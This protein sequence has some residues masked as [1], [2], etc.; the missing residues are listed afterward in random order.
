MSTKKLS[1]IVLATLCTLN[2]GSA[3]GESKRCPVERLTAEI[4]ARNEAAGQTLDPSFYRRLADKYRA[5]CVR[6]EKKIAEYGQLLKEFEA[7]KRSDHDGYI[8]LQTIF[9]NYEM[10]RDTGSLEGLAIQAKLQT[11]VQKHPDFPYIQ[12][13]RLTDGDISSVKSTAPWSPSDLIPLSLIVSSKYVVAKYQFRL[14]FYDRPAGVEAG[15]KKLR[16]SLMRTGAAPGSEI[17]SL[18]TL[19]PLRIL[20]FQQSIDVYPPNHEAVG[21]S[22]LL[23]CTNPFSRYSAMSTDESK[24]MRTRGVGNEYGSVNWINTGG[25]FKDFCGI[26]TQ[27]GKILYKFPEA[28]PNKLLT[29]IAIGDNGMSAAVAIGE[30]QTEDG[31]D[32][33]SKAVGNIRELLIWESGKSRRVKKLPKFENTNELGALFLAKKL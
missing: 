4:Q 17:V 3:L 19:H 27:A 24:E 5:D 15:K 2:V 12:D 32:G 29:P 7:G 18:D 28:P 8:I 30:G 11:I 6:A 25:E 22:H 21:E 1:G 26:V 16:R 23:V 20:T 31:E 9:S 33:P 14:A 10:L 13:F